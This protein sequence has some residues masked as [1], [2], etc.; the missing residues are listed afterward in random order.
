MMSRAVWAAEAVSANATDSQLAYACP[1]YYDRT[2][3]SAPSLRMREEGARS[4]RLGSSRTHHG[5]LH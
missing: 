2:P 5:R 1:P 3:L 4:A